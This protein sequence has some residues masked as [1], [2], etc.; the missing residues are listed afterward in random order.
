[1]QYLLWNASKSQRYSRKIQNCDP[2]FHH[3][4]YGADKADDWTVP[5]KANLS[6]GITVGIDKVKVVCK[7]L[8]NR[9][10]LKKMFFIFSI[11]DF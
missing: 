6:L 7:F 8:Q 2:A 10:Q 9:T 1:M 4:T 3:V 11:T 5:L